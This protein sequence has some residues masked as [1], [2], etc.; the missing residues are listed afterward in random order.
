VRGPRRPRL[1]GWRPDPYLHVGPDRLFNP[2]TDRVLKAGEP[3]HDLLRA[4]LADSGRGLEDGPDLE[5]LV[6]GGWLIP[7]DTDPDRLHRLKYVSLEAHTVC[8]QVC[9]FCPVSVAPRPAHFMPMSL[10]ER[11]VGE[12]AA[13][14]SPIEAVF[15][16]GYNEPT[17]DPR[18]VDLVTC[19]HAAGLPVAVLTNGAGLTPSRSERLLDLGGLA[20][21]C[22]NLSTLDRARYRRDRGHDHLAAVLE[23]LDYVRDLPVAKRMEIVVLGDG[24]ARHAEDTRQVRERFSA[25]RF[26]VRP[27]RLDERAEYFSGD[28]SRERLPGSLC[29]CEQMGSRPIQHLHINP[30]GQCVL[31]CQDY[32]ETVIVGDLRTDSL[33]DILAGPAFARAR[34]RVYGL[35]TAPEEFICH[36]CRWA[37]RS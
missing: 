18:F 20:Y 32:D 7:S 4:L 16:N 5:A 36:R 6:A 30:H 27:E 26:D 37:L 11:I 34:R 29:G 10:F 24:D 22:V 13:L 14:G 23:N 1:A 31:C 3:G 8:N 15:M 25:S 33:V 2:H 9:F 19:L 28:P 21:L 17:T 35:E 12:I